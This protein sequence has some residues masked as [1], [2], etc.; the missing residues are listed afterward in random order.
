LSLCKPFRYNEAVVQ[1]N[2]TFGTDKQIV[3]YIHIHEH[4]RILITLP[5]CRT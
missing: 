4:G 5:G 3:S 2:F 1:D